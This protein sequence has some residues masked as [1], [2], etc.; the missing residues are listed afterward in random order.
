MIERHNNKP[1]DL[2]RTIRL[3][4]L[5]SGAKL[6]LVQLSKS[7]GVV[8]IALQLPDSESKGQP[9]ARLTDKFP[10]STTLWLVL[11]KFEAGVAG[12][13][14]QSSRSQVC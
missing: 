5:T 14:S 8:S 11:R 12:G 9:N 1:V 2:T 6:E 13:A 7:A 4:G 10:S 3:S